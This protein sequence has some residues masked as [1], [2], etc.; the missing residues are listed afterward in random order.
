MIIRTPFHDPSTPIDL[1]SR[2][3]VFCL[4]NAISNDLGSPE[5][6]MI[7]EEADVAVPSSAAP[8]R[9]TLRIHPKLLMSDDE[10]ELSFLEAK[11]SVSK[12]PIESPWLQFETDAFASRK[13]GPEE[14][15]NFKPSSSFYKTVDSK[16]PDSSGSTPRSSV[17]RPSK[18]SVRAMR[19]TSFLESRNTPATSTPKSSR[20]DLRENHLD[21]R[22]TP[23]TS[24]PKSS[25]ADLRENHLDYLNEI[26]KV[27]LDTFCP[28]A[29]A[30]EWRDILVR[31]ALQA[32]ETVKPDVRIGDEMDP[33]NY[34]KVKKIEG[35]NRAQS[36][37]TPGFG[38]SVVIRHKRLLTPLEGVSVLIIRFP[39]EYERSEGKFTSLDALMKQEIEYLKSLFD[40]IMLYS[41][42]IVFCQKSVGGK[43]FDMFLNAGVYVFQNIRESRLLALSRV[44][45][46][47]IVTSFDRLNV[48]PK[49]GSCAKYRIMTFTV[50]KGL[51]LTRKS[52]M[53]IEGT[54]PST[55]G[56][57]I[58]KGETEE[59]L[60]QIEK[61]FFAIVYRFNDWHH[62][63]DFCENVLPAASKE[64]S[65][66]QEL[67]RTVPTSNPDCETD[68]VK[69]LFFSTNG[70]GISCVA[71]EIQTIE[72]Y[73]ESDICVGLFI[74]ELSRRLLEPCPAFICKKKILD[75]SL[76]YLFNNASIRFAVKRDEQIS[77]RVVSS[78]PVFISVVCSSCGASTDEMPMTSESWS[79]S[80]GKLLKLLFYTCGSHRYV[81]CSCSIA[82][83][84]RF[85]YGNHS[86]LFCREPI[87]LYQLHQPLSSQPPSL[88]FLNQ[89]RQETVDSYRSRIR[90]FYDDILDKL[91]KFKEAAN[92]RLESLEVLDSY[93][94]QASVDL[95]LALQKLQELCI[96]SD[97]N[98]VSPLDAILSHLLHEYE[99]WTASFRDLLDLQFRSYMGKYVKGM[100][101]S[102]KN[103]A[104][105]AASS[106]AENDICPIDLLGSSPGARLVESAPRVGREMN[107]ESPEL[108]YQALQISTTQLS[109]DESNPLYSSSPEKA[110]ALLNA[111]S[112]GRSRETSSIPTGS[113]MGTR[114]TN[115]TDAT[116]TDRKSLFQT[117]TD[118]WMNNFSDLKLYNPVY[119][120]L[121]RL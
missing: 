48:A 38:F 29:V 1:D 111:L 101:V 83:T 18:Y 30:P 54:N 22:N 40:R 62:L 87:V 95:E 71:P 5:L 114:R 121:F 23:T 42:R 17:R 24:T 27:S 64:D 31:I 8:A 61:A 7:D 76:I 106:N 26:A 66:I 88:E 81:N 60:C 108:P 20:A 104:D 107:P 25:R 100:R 96:S 69:F 59:T 34:I 79:L 47:E 63:S 112:L 91:L 46:A 77:T 41:P 19:K 85:R 13:L 105:D 45:G 6:D 58:L 110:Y 90:L 82:A 44:T 53:L 32:T 92:G 36:L 3:C 50:D 117:I 10:D 118:L 56:S 11:A 109:S 103:T 120:L 119:D 12:V 14:L 33:R 52:I 51:P 89:M 94:H 67:I 98:K 80:L 99:R 74:E 113:I 21:S 70:D 86:F 78:N 28:D 9:S 72:L 73:K 49:M 93:M 35:S 43:I 84:F 116:T 65:S 2:I 57:V 55:F 37:F 102:D 97:E 15:T 4:K 39:L 68:S 75:H 115:Q 16:E